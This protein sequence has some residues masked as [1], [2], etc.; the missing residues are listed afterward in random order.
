MLRGLVFDDRDGDLARSP[1][2]PLLAGVPVHFGPLRT[3]TDE[4]GE[5]RFYDEVQGELRVDAA[6]LSDG[7]V[8]P[9]GFHPPTSGRVEIPVFRTA[10]L[11]LRLFLDRD[12]DRRA[13]APL[14]RTATA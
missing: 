11:R 7:Y 10:V 9:A 8:M 3:R 2:E 1:D 13:P 14:I 5:F 6:T 4:E 12:G